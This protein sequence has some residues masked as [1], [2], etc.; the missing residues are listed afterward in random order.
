[1]NCDPR[2]VSKGH[3]KNAGIPQRSDSMGISCGNNENFLFILHKTPL[4]SE[5]S[6]IKL[7][8]KR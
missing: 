5:Y 4:P 2:S 1:M 6:N 7:S 3:R 8:P